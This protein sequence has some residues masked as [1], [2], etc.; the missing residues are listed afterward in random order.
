MLF[1][2]TACS[3][4]PKQA[5][6]TPAA[7]QKLPEN[8]RILIAYFSRVGN[9]EIS[10]EEKD[11]VSSASLNR[12]SNGIQGTT[13]LLAKDIQKA[14][15][16][17][18]FLIEQED[19]YPADY[20]VLEDMGKQEE[21]D[22]I[23]PKLASHIE[24]PEEYDVILLGF[25]NW[26][27]DMPM[28]VYSFLEEYDFSNKTILPFVTSGGSGFSDAINEIKAL[29]PNAT[30]TEGL[31]I[32]QSLPDDTSQRTLDWLDQYGLLR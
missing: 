14:T 20:Q 16:G 29:Q 19:K 7:D 27:Y 8:S 25:P 6:A 2:L 31:A 12:T 18:L 10:D 23:R 28:A 17:D 13:E 11:T 5:P 1:L 22:D 24:H 30:V 3:T 26:W 32:P 15:Q 4:Q 9:A 21:D